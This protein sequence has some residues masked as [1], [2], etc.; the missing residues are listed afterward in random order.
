MM[1]SCT[2]TGASTTIMVF[3][4]LVNPLKTCD[5]LTRA[6]TFRPTVLLKF[7]RP[8][9]TTLIVS[10]GFS[11]GLFGPNVTSLYL[12]SV[13]LADLTEILSNDSGL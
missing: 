9:N 12:A 2:E 3:V 8:L 7:L 5:E 13:P 6:S 1:L 11:I 4:I 10:I